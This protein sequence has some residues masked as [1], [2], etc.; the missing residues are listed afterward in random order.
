MPRQVRASG[1]AVVAVILCSVS[2]PF[3]GAETAE[4]AASTL[5]L[6]IKGSNL[7]AKPTPVPLQAALL[8]VTPVWE[9]VK[10]VTELG[11]QEASGQ[12]LFVS[13]LAVV[14]GN[15]PM[16]CTSVFT[17][18]APSSEQDF[19]VVAGKGEAYLPAKGWQS[20]SVGKAFTATSADSTK[21]I[22]FPVDRFSVDIQNSAIKKKTASKENVRGNDGRLVL[23]QNAGEWRVDFAVRMDDAVAEGQ[24]PLT[25][26]P[27]ASRK[28]SAGMPLVGEKRLL[29]AA[30]SF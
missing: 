29:D 9:D 10:A 15:R 8:V 12:P 21:P 25:L 16:D 5:T 3:V 30:R 14:L 17:A 20:T 26:C 6:S 22:H 18:G 11:G 27:I 19:L 28:K 24:M 23:D 13:E 1:L 7:Y 4:R 2:A